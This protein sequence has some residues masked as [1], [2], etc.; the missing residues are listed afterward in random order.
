[1]KDR[2]E[3][4]DGIKNGSEKCEGSGGGIDGIKNRSG[5]CV[6]PGAG[7]GGGDQRFF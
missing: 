2:A 5:K 3:G 1:V 4:I 7:G 6:G